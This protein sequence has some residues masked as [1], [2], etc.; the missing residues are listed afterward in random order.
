MAERLAAPNPPRPAPEARPSAATLALRAVVSLALVAGTALVAR[1][2][3]GEPPRDAALRLALRTT[4]ARLEVCR[5]PSARE[6]EALP[7]HMRSPRICTETA[8]DY[9][10]T[11]KLDGTERLARTVS[12]SGL[13]R[14]RPLAVEATLPT[15]AGRRHLELHFAPAPPPPDSPPDLLSA[16]AA[17]P[18]LHL[19]TPI[20]LAPGRILLLTLTED[21]EALFIRETPR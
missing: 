2:P 20:D 4:H 17:L 19:D 8:L 18:A 3:L 13:R 11:V 1:V 16:Y 9:H 5:E 6:L 15:P 10:L 21:G 14:T 7:I 12:P